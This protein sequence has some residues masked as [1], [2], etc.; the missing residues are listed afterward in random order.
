MFQEYIPKNTE[1]RVTIIGET[2]CATEIHS[3]LSERTLHDWRRYDNFEKTL[4][5]QR[6]NKLLQLMRSG[7][8]AFDLILPPSNDFVFL[9][10]NPNGRW[11]WIQQ[12]TGVNIA[13]KLRYI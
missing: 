4:Y 7:I 9:E 3:Q 10:V 13:K 1:F 5:L 2:I 11:W 6:C 12:L 8:W